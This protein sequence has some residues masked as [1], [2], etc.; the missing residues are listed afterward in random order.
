MVTNMR[1]RMS[2]FVVGLGRL[3]SKEGR[4]AMLIGDM[5]ISMLMV[6]VQHVEEEKLRDREE[7]KNKRAKI[8][9]ESGQQKNNANRVAQHKG[10]VSLLPVPSVVGTIQ[11]LVVMAPLVV[12][13]VVKMGIS[14]K[15]VQRTGREMV[16]GGN[17]AKSSSVAPPDRAAPR[18]ANFS[19]SGGTNVLYAINS[20]Q[21]QED[22]PDVIIGMIQVFDFTV[23]ALLDP[24]A[25]LSFVTLMLL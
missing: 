2:L 14:C 18:G 7:F 23:Y 20:R 4:D 3:S 8:G 21:V 12:S 17:R 19:T 6:Y 9:N 1:S 25:S 24:G 16:M 13:S 5:D 15:I 11:V 10:V 22:S